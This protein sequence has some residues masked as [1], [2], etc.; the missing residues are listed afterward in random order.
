MNSMTGFGRAEARGGGVAVT[1]ELKSVNN[2]FRDINMRCPR[3]LAALEP[4]I[5]ALVKSRFA[6]GR[7]EVYVRRVA[8]AGNT[9]IQMNEGLAEEVVQALRGWAQKVDGVDD[10]LSVEFLANIPGILVAGE[11]DA[12]PTS[13]WSIVEIAVEGAIDHMLSMRREEGGALQRDLTGYLQEIRGLLAQVVEH[14]D[15][16]ANRLELRLMER[17]NRLIGDRVDENRLAQEAAIQ[18]DKADI[19]EEL[20]RLGSH[21]DQFGIALEQS[22]PVGR[23]LDFLTQEMNREINTIGSKA[24]DA[25]VSSLVVEMKSI[26]ERMREQVSNVE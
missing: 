13:E 15:G 4:R 26:L 10:S 8:S 9:K 14:S 24:V 21:F 11:R 2:R 18:A 5:A 6:R 22:G 1:V 23:R 25:A 20:A 19:A 7:I 12:D 16:I 3:E 17:L